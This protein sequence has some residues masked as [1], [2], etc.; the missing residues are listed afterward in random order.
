MT[1]A[2]L[3]ISALR[4]AASAAG[5]EPTTTPSCSSRSLVAGSLSA[6]TVSACILRMISGGVLAGAKS[7]Y[8]EDTAGLGDRRQMRDCRRALGRRHREAAQL[9]ALN[10]GLNRA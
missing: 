7:A 6:A 1:G 4:K 3:S 10:E 9:A 5:V 2:H 8:Q